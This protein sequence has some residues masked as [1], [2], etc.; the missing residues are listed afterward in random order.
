MAAELRERLRAEGW[1]TGLSESQIVPVVIGEPHQTMRISQGLR[2]RGIWAPGIR[3]PSV[4]EGES[5]LRLGITAGHT[6]EMMDRLVEVL[7]ELRR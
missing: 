1:N 2:E 4:P 6:A 5:L 7:G 3:P